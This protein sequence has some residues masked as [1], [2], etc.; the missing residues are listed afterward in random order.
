[1]G[2]QGGTQIAYCLR[3]SCAILGANA[4]GLPSETS[5]K[6]PLGLT[7]T[8]HPFPRNL[9]RGPK[10]AQKAKAPTG[11]IGAEQ[12]MQ[13]LRTGS[14]YAKIRLLETG[15][16][17]GWRSGSAGALQA[18]GHRFKSCTGHHEMHEGR[19]CRIAGLFHC[20]NPSL[21]SSTTLSPSN[22]PGLAPTR[23]DLPGLRAATLI[24]YPLPL[25]ASRASAPRPEASRAHG[26][27][28]PRW[29][30]P[31]A[32]GRSRRAAPSRRAG[33]ASSPASRPRRLSC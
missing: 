15:Q 33:S 17:A 4:P 13:F 19:R 20:L 30:R 8:T 29:R 14:S 12:R 16:T 9:A 25:S 11:V 7:Q 5:P 6:Q 2:G 26:P 3:R 24:R 18:Q 1:M 27:A 10:S 23:H 28:T 31:K 32:C 22:A 21:S